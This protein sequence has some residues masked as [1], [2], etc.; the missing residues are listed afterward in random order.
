M[1]LTLQGTKAATKYAREPA[2]SSTKNAITREYTHK[3]NK[4]KW[5]NHNW[6]WWVLTPDIR[7]MESAFAERI[8]SLKTSS[9]IHRL[10]WPRVSPISYGCEKELKAQKPLCCQLLFCV[11]KAETHSQCGKI[12]I[13]Q[14]DRGST[15]ILRAL[16]YASF[17]DNIPLRAEWRS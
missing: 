4:E 10:G 7:G 14:K 16:H 5:G 15:N 12:P 6:Q 3:W 9:T 8:K 17:Q 1:H 2:M 11:A 13:S